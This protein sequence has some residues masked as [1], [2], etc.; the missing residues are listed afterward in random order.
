[1]AEGMNQRDVAAQLHVSQSAVSRIVRR[2]RKTNQHQALRKGKCGRKLSLSPKSIRL[3]ARES[4]RNP[5]ATARQIQMAV[6]GT[7]SDVSIDTV[8]RVLNSAGRQALRPVKSPSWT[9]AQMRVRL[10][11]LKKYRQWTVDHWKKVR[12][13]FTQLLKKIENKC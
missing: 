10:Q 4:I 8:R 2:Y 7:V 12:K 11:W 3:V 1:V 5:H 13:L 6:G 9:P